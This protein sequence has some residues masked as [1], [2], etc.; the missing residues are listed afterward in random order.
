MRRLSLPLLLLLA[1]PA[2]R[3]DLIRLK[4]GSVIEGKVIA[5]TAEAI[6]L[7]TGDGEMSVPRSRIESI[8]ERETPF[9]VYTQRAAEL[10]ENDAQ[11]H[12]ELA[13][14]CVRHDLHAQAIAM[15]RQAL[16][17]DP[18]HSG[19]RAAL[20]R[21]IDPRARRL[22]RSAR[23][24]QEDGQFVEA[25]KPLID[26]L[27]NY[28][29]SRYAAEAHHLLAV[30]YAERKDYD[31]AFVRWRRAL[32]ADPT[33]FD[34]AEGAARAALELSRWADALT[35][36][37]R[38]LA[39]QGEAPEA[40]ALRQRAEA[41][42]ELVE[43]KQ[44]AQETPKDPK[45]LSRQGELL[46]RLGLAD[47]AFRR[48]EEAYE[49]GARSPELLNRLADQ[50]ERT[51]QVGRAY[52]L[53]DQLA[54]LGPASDELVRRRARL[55]PLLLIPDALGTRD[56]DVR[57]DILRR[58]ARSG[59]SFE[60]IENA[61]REYTVRPDAEPGRTDGSFLVDEILVRT[62][63]IAYVPKGYTPRRSWPLV[64]ALHREDDKPS[65]HFFN[66]ETV[67]NSERY[68]LLLPAVPEEQDWEYDHIRVVLSALEHAVETWNVDTNR[69]FLS[70]TG[71][72]GLLA[73]ATALRYPDRFAGL[74]TRT[75]PIDDVSK[76]YL[77]NA[78]NLAV[79]QL[80]P[81]RTNPDVLRTGRDAAEVLERYG[82]AALREEVPG[83]RHPALP[84][85]NP[86]VLQW[87]D[88]ARRRPY[89]RR[90]NL[91]TFEH[92]AGKAYWVRIDEF[93]D[94]VFDPDRKLRAPKSPLNFQ[95]SP[96]QLR[97]IYLDE[98]R[99]RLAFVA[100]V[101]SPGGRIEVSTKHVNALTVSLDDRLVDL[102][103]PVTL[104]LNGRR[105][106]QGKVH[107]SLE[108]LFENARLHGDPRLA[109]SARL[110]ISVT[111]AAARDPGAP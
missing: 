96:E 2:V 26:V 81:E 9:E 90:V 58:I 95:Y 7:K 50:Y 32:K 103:E 40:Q 36:T 72:G 110:E 12:I 55:K 93:A 94:S 67:A 99:A 64:I 53:C 97:Q 39:I 98:M 14:Y 111:R 27:D 6:R 24:Y 33:F 75:A 108:Y 15:L 86:K 34:A 10:P 35:F 8:E 69:V 54:K 22:I 49:A 60:Y 78:V 68:L 43:V 4:N 47:R 107:R 105:I 41:L 42:R 91:T 65:N 87:M 11:A 44:Q 102:D 71:T 74:L 25:E 82:A 38:A 85:L 84:E 18:D 62:D 3:A 92:A 109:C 28:P 1:A 57:E 61:L 17:I 52:E 77:P 45:L 31:K 83:R 48:L 59:A 30:G 106:F 101:A 37:E 56:P 5:R 88:N 73:W 70:G 19:A 29:E 46:F 80:A 20:K 13:E 79:Y 63:Y 100:A 23:R 16:A 89:P 21:I 66:W 51:G 76:L 104:I